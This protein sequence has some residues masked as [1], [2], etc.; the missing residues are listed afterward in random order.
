MLPRLSDAF[1]QPE[2]STNCRDAGVRAYVIDTGNAVSRGIT[3]AVAT[4][5]SNA[6]ACNHSPRP[7]AP[8]CSRRARSWQGRS[9][10]ASTRRM[11]STP[12]AAVNMDSTTSASSEPALPRRSGPASATAGWKRGSFSKSRA[13]NRVPSKRYG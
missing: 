9:A 12:S 3:V 8:G 13:S 10:H 1:E 5:N 6:D 4:G 11:A 2:A 7:V